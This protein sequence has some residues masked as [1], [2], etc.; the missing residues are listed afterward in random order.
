MQALVE[1]LVILGFEDDATLAAELAQVLGRIGVRV[2]I[3]GRKVDVDELER[4]TS[5]AALVLVAIAHPESAGSDRVALVEQLL[6]RRSRGQ[7]LMAAPQGTYSGVLLDLDRKHGVGLLDLGRKL[8]SGGEQTKRL[9][10]RVA[11]AIVA[12][13]P[14]DLPASLFRSALAQRSLELVSE[15]LALAASRPLHEWS[16][17]EPGDGGLRPSALWT[18]WLTVTRSAELA[19]LAHH[20]DELRVLELLGGEPEREPSRKAARKGDA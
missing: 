10:R 19:R 9:R 20:L 17:A 11:A 18:S 13:R 14:I 5:H 8:G 3:V 15:P 12:Q 6:A 4:R 1:P 7:I 16:L 2:E